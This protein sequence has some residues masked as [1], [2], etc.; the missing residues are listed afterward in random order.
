MHTLGQG[1]SRDGPIGTL[2]RSGR[3]LR[4]NRSAAVLSPTPATFTL[5]EKTHSTAPVNF[6]SGLAASNATPGLN[7]AQRFLGSST[8]QSA[9]AQQQQSLSGVAATNVRLNWPK[10]TVPTQNVFEGIFASYWRRNAN[11]AAGLAGLAASNAT[12]GLNAAQR[13]L[14]SS[15]FQSALAQQQQSLSGV[16]A[17]NVRLN[18][19][20]I[21]VPTQNV[22]EGIF[23]SYWRRNANF[24]AGLAGLAASNA[25]PE[26]LETL[27]KI[28]RHWRELLRQASLPSNLRT[29]EGLT[30]DELLDFVQ[31]HG[32]SLYL[33]TPPRVARSFIR[34]K[35]R[36]AVRRILGDRRPAILETCKETLAKCDSLSTL[37]VRTALQQAIAALE[38]DMYYPAQATAAL[39]LDR[40][41]KLDLKANA[42]LS[43]AAR[44]RKGESVGAFRARRSDLDV[45]SSYIATTLWE[46]FAH[47]HPDQGDRVPSTFSRHASTHALGGRQYSRRNAVQ[48]IMAATT[49]VAYL[50]G[51]T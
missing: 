45:W 14:G 7:A 9:L 47:Y 12:P 18:W 19:P 51:L 43:T 40:L 30:S 46:A 17:T 29:I 36:A 48:G 41:L 34:A 20:K 26:W 3:R 23:A 5:V 31:E 27:R 25:T 44:R 21:T 42:Q 6:K 4:T 24:A 28:E 15:T 37:E 16:A 35:D 13:F 32:V 50:N 10:I 33:V 11:F 39:V 38:Q 8:F 49:V 22:F 1:E 2:G